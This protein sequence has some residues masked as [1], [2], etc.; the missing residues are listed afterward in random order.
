MLEYA[1]YRSKSEEHISTDYEIMRPVFCCWGC[2]TWGRYPGCVDYLFRGIGFRF[3]TR[4]RPKKLLSLYSLPPGFRFI[5][6]GKP[7]SGHGYSPNS[8]TLY[9]F[10]DSLTNFSRFLKSRQMKLPPLVFGRKL[11]FSA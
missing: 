11:S 4:K 5:Q 8:I 10:P 1:G 3:L 9:S 6:R 7:L 2:Y